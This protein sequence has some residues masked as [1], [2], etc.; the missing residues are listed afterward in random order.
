MSICEKPLILD[1]TQHGGRV[2]GQRRCDGR[3]HRTGVTR[4]QIEALAADI[5]TVKGTEQPSPSR[6]VRRLVPVAQLPLAADRT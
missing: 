3:L 6:S 5:A 1:V 2:L 4:Q